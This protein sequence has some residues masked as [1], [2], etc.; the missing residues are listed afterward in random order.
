MLTCY[1]LNNRLTWGTTHNMRDY[2]LPLKDYG[3]RVDVSNLIL[4]HFYTG[5]GLTS[6]VIRASSWHLTGHIL[7]YEVKQS[8]HVLYSVSMLRNFQRRKCCKEITE[9]SQAIARP[10]REVIISIVIRSVGQ[11]S[12]FGAPLEIFKNDIVSRSCFPVIHFF[13]VVSSTCRISSRTCLCNW[14]RDR[15]PGNVVLKRVFILPSN[16]SFV[17]FS[18]VLRA[19]DQFDPR[20]HCDSPSLGCGTPCSA[21]SV[22][23]EGLS[24]L[25]E[26][27]DVTLPDYEQNWRYDGVGQSVLRQFQ[28]K[29]GLSVEGGQSRR[30]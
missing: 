20:K 19:V 2:W 28:H 8:K 10:H 23:A 7:F 3:Q 9:N 22:L 17:F 13:I 11:P 18:H 6:L 5:L 29:V 24:R 30:W 26:F 12:W 1:R 27:P 25:L 21:V 16:S 15:S 4:R 14:M